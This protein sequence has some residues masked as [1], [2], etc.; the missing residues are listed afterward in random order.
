[1][2]YFAK[3]LPVEG[4]AQEGWCFYKGELLN[5]WRCDAHDITWCTIKGQFLAPGESYGYA[6]CEELKTAKLFL[7]SRD[8]QVGDKVKV[9]RTKD[10]FDN[11]NFDIEGTINSVGNN[12]VSVKIDD[13]FSPFPKNYCIKVIGSILSAATWVREG[14]EFEEDEVE[15]WFWH[16]KQK[17]LMFKVSEDW[18]P[19]FLELCKDKEWYERGHYMIKGPCGFYH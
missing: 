15:E 13:Y 10:N 18:V 3:Y 8:I 4:P 5:A 6:D 16:I 12:E 17:A 1:M 7:C 14:D 19:K 11:N 9:P 2:K